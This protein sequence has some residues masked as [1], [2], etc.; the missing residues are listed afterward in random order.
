MG[1][2]SDELHSH[3]DLL[4]SWS[5]RVP[6]PGALAG[7]VSYLD[8]L[9]STL[10][11]HAHMPPRQKALQDIGQ[12]LLTTHIKSQEEMNFIAEKSLNVLFRGRRKNCL[13]AIGP[14]HRGIRF[15]WIWRTCC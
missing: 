11:G 15:W 13:C 14:S 12:A 2:N 9:G 7:I 4:R 1:L 10:R 5:D 3:A 8:N 6:D